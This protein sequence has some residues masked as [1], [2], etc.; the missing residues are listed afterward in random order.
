MILSD[1]PAACMAAVHR[2]A[3]LPAQGRARQAISESFLMAL[4]RKVDSVGHPSVAVR[5]TARAA[6]ILAAALAPWAA[7]A[8]PSSAFDPLPGEVA[9]LLPLLA[10]PSR[11]LR[12][13]ATQ[14]I[15]SL[16]PGVLPLLEDAEAM[17]AAEAAW[18]LRGIRHRL[19]QEAV[20][21]AV[22]PTR[23]AASRPDVSIAEACAAVVASRGG[24]IPLAERLQIADRPVGQR[25]LQPLATG[26]ASG[27]TTYWEEIETLLIRGDCRLTSNP[28]APGHLLLRPREP[29]DPETRAAA[30]GPLWVELL[31]L[32]PVPADA[33]RGL[34][35]MLR[36]IWEPRMEPVMVR[37]PMASL[38]AE[39]PSG[40]VV[41]PQ[42]RASVVE[43]AVRPQEGWVDLPVLLKPAPAAVD[44]LATL[45]GT[46]EIWLPAAESDVHFQLDQV[47]RLPIV[48]RLGEATVR[49]DAVTLAVPEERRG[50]SGLQRRGRLTVRMTVSYPASEA[51]QS[52]HTW[53]T[54]RPIRCEI[55]NASVEGEDQRVVRRDDRGL[56][57][58]AVFLVPCAAAPGDVKGGDLL[59]PGLRVSWRLPLAVRQTQIDFRLVDILLPFPAEARP[60]P[61]T[62]P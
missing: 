26:P 25:P 49:L 15:T 29:E 57:R 9:A 6:V 47:G 23:V 16:G 18:R 35:G 1:H 39:G 13:L 28:A 52:H 45:R 7:R 56:T 62:Q 31:R 5:R 53:I 24:A 4:P 50:E 59:P 32:Q 33:P 27:T 40:E 44:R 51:L 43:G 2:A 55:G 22:E 34:R 10:D 54:L 17:A 14:R 37:L 30:C 38:I 58:E 42:Q 60:S 20:A 46:V 41:P 8:A 12:E 61:R 48:R 19:E 3:R 21:E 11:E 36:V